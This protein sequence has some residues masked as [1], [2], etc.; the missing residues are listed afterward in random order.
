MRIFVV[1]DH[2]VVRKGVRSV[3]RARK[4][5]EVCGEASN[6]QEAVLK[7]LSL[8]P[9]LI[10]MDVTMPVL[11]GLSATRQIKETLPQIPIIILSV[12]DGPEMIHAAQAA[13]AQGFVTKSAVA[14]A[15]LKAVD[16][17]LR[18]ETFFAD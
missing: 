15:L 17:V 12:H 2:E 14:P 16:A 9:D 1:D 13:G 11:D 18:G 8:N 6:G 4:N 5:L 3:L 10:L 7:A